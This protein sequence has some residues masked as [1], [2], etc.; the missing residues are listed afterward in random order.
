MSTTTFNF[1]LNDLNL[2]TSKPF[3]WLKQVMDSADFIFIFH[4]DGE[5]RKAND[6]SWIYADGTARAFNL[7]QLSLVEL[8]HLRRKALELIRIASHE[9]F[10]YSYYYEPP[11]SVNFKYVHP[12]NPKTLITIVDGTDLI[13]MK[14]LLV[15][16]IS[17]ELY[18]FPVYH[19]SDY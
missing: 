19:S 16:S 4:Y 13:T 10:V 14:E 9:R 5:F 2:A 12:G 17:V 18:A 7:G 11:N 6:G 15:R 8:S 1:A 3:V